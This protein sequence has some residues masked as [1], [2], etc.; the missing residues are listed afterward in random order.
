LSYDEYNKIISKKELNGML[1]KQKGAVP[2]AIGI[3]P[4]LCVRN[5]F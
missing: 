1:R 5:K 2:I 3:I 4:P